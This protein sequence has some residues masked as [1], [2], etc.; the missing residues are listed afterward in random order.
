LSPVLIIEASAEGV[1]NGSLVVFLLMFISSLIIGRAYCGWVCPGAGCQEAIFSVRDKGVSKGDY[2]KWV[3]WIPWIISIAFLVVKSGGYNKFDFLFRTKYG[4]SIADV[5]GMIAYLVVLL[6][7]I[8]IPAFVFG[9]RAF[10][11]YVCWMA[12]FMILG[13]KIRNHFAWP[14]LRLTAL[15][16]NCTHCKKCS[17]NCPMGLQVESMVIGDKMENSEC[18]LCGTCVDGCEFDAIRY[19]FSINRKP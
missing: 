4:F 10:C 11:H 5:S 17:K 9:K 15:P 7:L 1:I 3:L 14:S 6:G 19:T 12:P 8:V 13:R 16:D 2:V 18:I